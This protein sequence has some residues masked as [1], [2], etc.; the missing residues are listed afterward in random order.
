MKR[1][2]LMA[3]CL[4]S[5]L[6]VIPATA[7][8]FVPFWE[9]KA[10]PA[11]WTLLAAGTPETVLSV[12][13]F[14]VTG[15]SGTGTTTFKNS[16]PVADTETIE[17]PTSGAEGQ[18]EMLTFEVVC[19]P[20]GNGPFPC[21]TGESYKFKGA[22]S[23]GLPVWPSELSFPSNDTFEHAEL[24]VECASS[25]SALYHPPGHV[26]NPKIAVNALKSSAASGIFRHGI[27][28]FELLGTD[29]LKALGHGFVR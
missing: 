28:Y 24:E 20:N 11:G 18:D 27:N 13:S 15:G 6:A 12:G 7:Q 23:A 8:A 17:N 1:I 19:A 10:P 5:A 2:T 21:A 25:A 14:G 4:I 9:V 3:V 26:W 22:L 16:C 29:S